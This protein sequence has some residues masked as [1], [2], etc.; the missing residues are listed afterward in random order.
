MC[1]EAIPEFNTPAE[2]LLKSVKVEQFLEY[3]KKVGTL[4]EETK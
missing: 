3:S 4:K 1:E 2:K